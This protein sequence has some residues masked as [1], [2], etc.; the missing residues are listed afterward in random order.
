MN[1]TA[2]VKALNG[3]GIGYGVFALAAPRMM[4]RVYGIAE[5][6]PELRQMTR[7]WGTTLLSMSIMSAAAGDEGQD[8]RLLAVGLGNAIAGIAELVAAATDGL[9]VKAAI[10]GAVTSAAV[11]GSCI[12]ARSLD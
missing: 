10:P 12:W 3:I 8:S 9:P 5:T 6:T 4:Q 11:A 2:V 7:L 1:K